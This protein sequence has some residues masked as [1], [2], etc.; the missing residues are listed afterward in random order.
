MTPERYQQLTK[1]FL[2]VLDCTLEERSRMLASL[3]KDDPEMFYE[4]QSLLAAHQE[5]S[6]LDKSLLV[7]SQNNSK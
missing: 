1:L 6:M 4:V 3:Y 5:S 2:A 7:T